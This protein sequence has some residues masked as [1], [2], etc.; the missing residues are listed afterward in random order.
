MYCALIDTRRVLI[1]LISIYSAAR[2]QQTCTKLMHTGLRGRKSSHTENVLRSPCHEE[3]VW[4]LI[5]TLLPRWVPPR[6]QYTQAHPILRKQTTTLRAEA[7][8]KS[9]LQR[10]RLQAHQGPVVRTPAVT[11]QRP[12][13]LGPT[14]HL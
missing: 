5:S 7:S 9:T 12:G 8:L 6:H 1:I 11:I 4:H 3:P 10:V 2:P 14:A 13:V